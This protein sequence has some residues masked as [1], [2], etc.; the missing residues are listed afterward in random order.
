MNGGCFLWR[1]GPIPF[2]AGESIAIALAKAGV[3]ELG[4]GGAGQGLRYFC[5]I[6]ACQN[7]LV[8]IDGAVV[9]ACL[10]PARDGV[11]VDTPEGGHD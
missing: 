8:A 3:R 1:G 6:G 5:G 7:C 11:H 9:E 2:E 10:T 4:A